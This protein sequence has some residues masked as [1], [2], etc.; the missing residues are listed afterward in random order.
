MADQKSLHTEYELM[1][2]FVFSSMWLST[3]EKMSFR[4]IH[5]FVTSFELFFSSVPP[6][7][8]VPLSASDQ[9]P[10]PLWCWL[11]M[12]LPVCVRSNAGLSVSGWYSVCAMLR[13]I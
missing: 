11:E 6:A 4:V 12:F 2:I 5:L 7:L 10:L 1:I 13:W 8:E 9:L 3:C